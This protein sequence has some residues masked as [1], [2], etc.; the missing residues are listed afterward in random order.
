MGRRVLPP[1]YLSLTNEMIDTFNLEL[2]LLTFSSERDILTGGM[3]W[4]SQGKMDVC[5]L[6]CPASSLPVWTVLNA[7]GDG[8]QAEQGGWTSCKAEEG[9]AD[10]HGIRDRGP[11]C[12]Q[13]TCG[14]L[15][16]DP[17]S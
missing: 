11:S 8:A 14:Y 1:G 5:L 17:S 3:G 7:A 9:S 10:H 6:T 4:E 12:R 2:N 16:L 15:Q 13:E